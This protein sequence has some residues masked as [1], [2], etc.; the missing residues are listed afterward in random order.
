V[1]EDRTEGAVMEWQPIET[2]KRDRRIPSLAYVPDEGDGSAWS[3]QI[4]EWDDDYYGL[5]T[6]PFWR[7]LREQSEAYC[8]AHQP[9]HW[10][11]L[12]DPPASPRKAGS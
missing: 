11:P 8:R 6:R 1:D 3:R 9:T 4:A 12:P 7:Y 2:A 5:P 10:M